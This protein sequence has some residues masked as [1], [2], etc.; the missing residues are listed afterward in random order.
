MSQPSERE[1]ML[2]GELYLAND[3]ELVQQR[4]QA[5]QLFAAYNRTTQ[6][7]PAERDRLLRALLGHCG[8]K[9]WIE[10]PFYCDYGIHINLGVGVFLNFNCIFLDCAMIEVGDNVQLG[11]FVQLYTAYHPV[12]ALERIAGPELASPI[13]IGKSCWIGGGAI[14]CPGVSIGANTTIG[15]G[16]V[17]VRDIP[18]NVVAVGNPCRVVRQLNEPSVTAL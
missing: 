12:P 8:E 16:S 2:A 6:D 13:H 9:V 3:P 15:A 4:R 18:P 1:K 14:V 17:V 7:E 10:P 5:R 11:P